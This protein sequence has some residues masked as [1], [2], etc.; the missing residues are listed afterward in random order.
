MAIMHG[1][2][3]S[4]T[5][6]EVE[7]DGLPLRPNQVGRLPPETNAVVVDKRR[8]KFDPGA[9]AQTNNGPGYYQESEEQSCKRESSGQSFFSFH[10]E[11]KNRPV[12]FNQEDVAQADEAVSVHRRV[13]DDASL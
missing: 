4:T 13:S 10:H 5:N 9:R 6:L 3:L 12:V 11:K 1:S 8:I 2:T 7:K